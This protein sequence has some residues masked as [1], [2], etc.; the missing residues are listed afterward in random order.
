MSWL[1]D[2][3]SLHLPNHQH[4]NFRM[5]ANIQNLANPGDRLVV[6]GGQG[7]TAILKDL[8]KIDSEAN[9]VSVEPYLNSRPAAQKALTFN[10][11]CLTPGR[12]IFPLYYPSSSPSARIELALSA[13]SEAHPQYRDKL[14]EGISIAW[15]KV[16][17]SLGGGLSQPPLPGCW[18]LMGLS[19][20]RTITSPTFE[21]GRRVRS[22]LQ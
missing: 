13:R 15:S 21:A 12:L 10:D 14:S 5:Y 11:A 16:P 17:Y 9:F 2:Y 22:S 3:V 6:I 8:V 19:C 18:N 20:S 7:H 4:S 1:S